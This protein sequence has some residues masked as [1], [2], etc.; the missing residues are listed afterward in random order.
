MAFTL[1][2]EEKTMTIPGSQF[3]HKTYNQIEAEKIKS[4]RSLYNKF[5]KHL[6]LTEALVCRMVSKY[7][8][9]EDEL[10]KLERK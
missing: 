5:R 10:R 8:T 1:T 4:M 9:L 6:K 2:K 3:R 7:K